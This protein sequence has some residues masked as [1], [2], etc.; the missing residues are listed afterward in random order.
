MEDTGVGLLTNPQQMR[1]SESEP[2]LPACLIGVARVMVRQSALSVSGQG[3]KALNHMELGSLPYCVFL[4]SDL[5]LWGL[6]S[7][8]S[9]SHF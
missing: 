7:P 4:L 1:R 9:A 5:D 3:R 6:Q 8:S 2:I